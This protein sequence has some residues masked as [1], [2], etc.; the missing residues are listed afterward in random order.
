[1]I[2]PPAS[3]FQKPFD[4]NNVD[5]PS[6]PP[7]PLEFF[8]ILPLSYTEA[9]KFEFSHY[10]VALNFII[11]RNDSVTSFFLP[12]RQN[13]VSNAPSPF[14]AGALPFWGLGKKINARDCAGFAKI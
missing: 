10:P 4:P 12:H 13:L 14:K 6:K 7:G 3:L 8:V 11:G 2:L 9:V 5:H 1:M